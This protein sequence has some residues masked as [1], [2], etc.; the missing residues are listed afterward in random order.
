MKMF[1]DGCLAVSRWTPP[2]SACSGLT[3]EVCRSLHTNFLLGGGGRAID[4]Q[5]EEA[6]LRMNAAAI[7][8]QGLEG[9]QLLCDCTETM[10]HIMLV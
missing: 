4:R 9:N 8:V 1:S 2:G 3:G 5:R 6:L 10:L 7:K